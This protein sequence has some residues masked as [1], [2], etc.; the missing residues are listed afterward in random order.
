MSTSRGWT[1]TRA[2]AAWQGPP[3]F[4][5]EVGVSEP[6]C[7]TMRLKEQLSRPGETKKHLNVNNTDWAKVT[8]AVH[9]GGAEPDPTGTKV[10]HG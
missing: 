9:T 4:Q 6:P 7:G 3:E 10:E 2:W 8:S 5:P 1:L